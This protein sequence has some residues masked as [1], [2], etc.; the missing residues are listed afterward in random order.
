[1]DQHYVVR[2][3]AVVMTRDDSSGGWVPL[4]GAGLSHVMICRGGRSDDS[5]HAGFLIRGERLRDQAVILECVLKKDLIYNKVNPIF[6]HWKVE[7]DKFG[8]TFQSPADAVTF[9]QSIKD[10]IEE[11]VEGSLTSSSSSQG[12]ADVA[13]DIVTIHTD[14]E[15]SSNSRKEMLPKH[16]TIVTSESSSSC[17]IRSPASDEFR[18]GLTQADAQ[19]SQPVV[20]YST[21]KT[22]LSNNENRNKSGFA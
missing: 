8:L 13:E 17:Y 11:L 21:D 3:R 19:P 2:V 9:E 7:D 5:G 6:H 22:P 4:G 10:V 18:H 12:E 15:S 16:I 20:L 14:S 1:M